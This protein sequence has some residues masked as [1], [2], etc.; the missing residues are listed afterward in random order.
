MFT[1]AKLSDALIPVLELDVHGH[2][3]WSQLSQRGAV[4]SI[5]TLKKENGTCDVTYTDTILTALILHILFK[6]NLRV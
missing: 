5:I 1:C 3:Y 4:L 2:C 6:L